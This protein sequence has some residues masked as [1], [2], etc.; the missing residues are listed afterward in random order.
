MLKPNVET[1]IKALN[2]LNAQGNVV[3]LEEVF[4]ESGIKSPIEQMFFAQ[5]DSFLVSRDIPL[6]PQYK[7][8]GYRVDFLV[9]TMAYFVNSPINYT[10]EELDQISKTLPRYVVELDGH[11]FHEKT[12]Q[13]VEHDKKRQRFITSSGYTVYRF[14]GSEVFK[15]CYRCVYDIIR[16]AEKDLKTAIKH[17][18]YHPSVFK[19]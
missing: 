3:S 7:I 6:K 11:D 17:F 2:D 19:K 16:M 13:Q 9:E 1:F 10:S 4:N 5:W 8:G 12:K 14:S 15:D 18:Q